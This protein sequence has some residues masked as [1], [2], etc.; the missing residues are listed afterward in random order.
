MSTNSKP[1]NPGHPPVGQDDFERFPQRDGVTQ[2]WVL[3]EP[4]TREAER[5][6]AKWN[7]EDGLRFE[8]IRCPIDP[9][10]HRRAGARVSALSVILPNFQ[11]LDFV[12]GPWECLV[13]EPVVQFFRDAGFTGFEVAPAK[14]KFADTSRQPPRFWELLAKGSA[15]AISPGSGYQVLSVCPGCGLTD[16]TRI[17][18]PTKVVD[19]SRW[20]GSDFFHLDPIPS[21]IFV[22]ERVVQALRKTPFEGWK[23]FS[24]LEKKESFDIAFPG[25]R[26]DVLP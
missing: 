26:Y 6:R 12:W 22:T 7:Q 9:P 11:P 2:F 15:G 19:E 3:G 16:E 17:D 13:R 10:G 20:D 4:D 8:S 18:D 23:A 24:L 14:V 5:K 21:W 25:P 1:F